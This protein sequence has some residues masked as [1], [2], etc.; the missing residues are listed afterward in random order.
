[1]W[2]ESLDINHSHGLH[3]QPDAIFTG[4]GVAQRTWAGKT[5]AA[6]AHGAIG[7]AY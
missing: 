4:G 3:D 2:S 6:Q 5:L 7:Q 1:M